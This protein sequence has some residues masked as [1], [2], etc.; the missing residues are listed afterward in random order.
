MKK[1]PSE[2][3]DSERIVEV[4][5][6]YFP[7]VEFKATGGVVYHLAL[8]DMFHNFDEQ[9]DK[10]LVDLLMMIDEL[11]TMLGQTHYGVALAFKEG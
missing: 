9:E 6:K 3:A 2:A 8:N 10:I 4:L 11:C 1:D 7:N 5:Y